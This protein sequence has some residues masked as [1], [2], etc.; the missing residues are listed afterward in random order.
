MELHRN[1][2]EYKQEYIWQVSELL[3]YDTRTWPEFLV[4]DCKEFVNN[5]HAYRL[6]HLL[7]NIQEFILYLDTLQEEY[8]DLLDDETLAPQAQA[9]IQWM[10]ILS[11]V[12]FTSASKERMLTRE[13]L[14]TVKSI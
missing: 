14:K 3:C 5:L 8:A 9:T 4:E 1:K 6:E 13:L 10:F 7:E 12:E 2:T 11:C